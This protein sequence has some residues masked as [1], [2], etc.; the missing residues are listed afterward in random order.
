MGFEPTTFTLATCKP[1]AAN[2]SNDNDLDSCRDP[3]RSA[4]AARAE[5]FTGEAAQDRVVSKADIDAVI[6]AWPDLPEA[7]RAGIVAMVRAA[8]YAIGASNAQPPPD[9]LR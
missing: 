2:Y 6:K 5:H 7:I 3:S 9:D 8:Q 1:T 4:F